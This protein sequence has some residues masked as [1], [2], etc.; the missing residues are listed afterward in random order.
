[1]NRYRIENTETGEV[2]VKEAEYLQTAIDSAGWTGIQCKCEVLPEQL[3]Q[4][5]DKRSRAERK[6]DKQKPTAVT[7][8][9]PGEKVADHVP[10]AAALATVVEQDN[11]V[12][13]SVVGVPTEAEQAAYD[14]KCQIEAMVLEAEVMFIRIGQLLYNARE[15][16]E[17]SILHYE[18]YKEYVESLK[19][20]VTASY[21]WATRLSNI[22]EYL[23]MNMGLDEKLLAEIGVAKLTRLLPLARKGGLTLEVIEAARV[24]S[25]LDLREEL[26][27]NIGA[28]EGE[29][30]LIIC[31]RC[32]EQFNARTATRVK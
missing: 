30:D 22:Y 10:T 4:R 5:K 32:G 12:A 18:S 24:L 15:N 29:P 20:P 23:V 7:V 16:A 31:P 6:R 2:V 27:Q 8:V 3:P 25:D 9:K 28:S 13:E 11:V 21:S 17:W 14:H 19:L 26:G 1:M